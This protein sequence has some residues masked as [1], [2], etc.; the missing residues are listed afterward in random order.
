MSVHCLPWTSKAGIRLVSVSNTEELR[1]CAIPGGKDMRRTLALSAGDPERRT[2]LEP[3][4][5]SGGSAGCFETRRSWS[6]QARLE[7][8]SLASAG[9]A[10]R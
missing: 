3:F 1:V 4:W 7:G 5:L 6:R 2:Q 10:Y 9:E 8:G